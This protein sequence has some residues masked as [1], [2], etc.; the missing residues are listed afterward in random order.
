MDKNEAILEYQCPGCTNG[1]SLSCVTECDKGIGCG[2]HCSGTTIIPLGSVFLGMPKGFNRVGS[3]EKMPLHIFASYDDFCKDWGRNTVNGYAEGYDMWNVP[4]WKFLDQHGN[5]LVRGLSPRT[6]GTFLHVIL[7][8]CRD[9]INCLEI[10]K[11]LQ[12]KMD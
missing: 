9:K 2:S 4:V 11:E 1:P 5:T 3:A 10:T 8:D 12:E 7:G 6:N